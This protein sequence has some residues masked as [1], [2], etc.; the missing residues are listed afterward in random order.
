MQDA[1]EDAEANL[2]TYRVDH[3]LYDG[4]GKKQIRIFLIHQERIELP[5]APVLSISEVNKLVKQFDQMK[6]MMKQMPGMMKGAKKGRFKLP[7]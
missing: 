6:K 7:F 2:K 3:S 1:T 4:K 5:E